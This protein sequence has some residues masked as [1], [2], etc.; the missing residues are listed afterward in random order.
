VEKKKFSPDQALVAAL[1]WFAGQPLE[2][3]L[4]LVQ[5]YRAQGAA[6]VG[7]QESSSR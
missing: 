2:Q 1:A 6:E 5:G 7:S 4:D 3:R